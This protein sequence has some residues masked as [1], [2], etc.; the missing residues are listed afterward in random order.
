MALNLWSS[1]NHSRQELQHLRIDCAVIGCGV[2]FLI[3]QT[4]SN[5]FRSVP[6]DE[7][8]FVLETFLLSEERDDLVLYRARKLSYAIRLENH[9]NLSGK[10]VNLPRTLPIRAV[11][12]NH[13]GFR[14]L[15]HSRPNQR[16][17]IHI[18]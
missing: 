7:C 1:L 8:E 17:T 9:R 5:R 10:H 14:G 3:P 4:N 2:F 18:P 11:I 13:L 16:L 6:D 15:H 12:G